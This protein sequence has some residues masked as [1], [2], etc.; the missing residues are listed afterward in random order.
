MTN[1]EKWIAN[2][3]KAFKK[4][5]AKSPKTVG[6]VVIENTVAV[7]TIN[8]TDNPRIGVAKCSPNDEFDLDTGLAIAYCRMSGF[9][10]PNYVLTDEP[11]KVY[12]SELEVGEHFKYNN[13]TYVKTSHGKLL[14]DL[15]TTCYT[16][17]CLNTHEIEDFFDND[18]VEPIELDE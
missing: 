3:S 17:Y 12:I 2:W 13:K 11:E 16:T 7:M 1:K 6:A 4:V 15:N 9:S 8:T 10:V 5:E 14:R 18:Y